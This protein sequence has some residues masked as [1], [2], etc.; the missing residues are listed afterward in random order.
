MNSL[1]KMD[2]IKKLRDSS[3]KKY[4]RMFIERDVYDTMKLNIDEKINAVNK[5][6]KRDILE[7]VQHSESVNNIDSNE[8]NTIINTMKPMHQMNTILSQNFQDIIPDTGVVIYMCCF[9]IYQKYTD[10]TP[11]LSYVLCSGTI[12]NE[13]I[14]T[15]PYKKVVT[16]EKNLNLQQY[17]NV[18]LDDIVGFK[19]VNPIGYLESNLNDKTLY[20]VFYDVKNLIPEV[21]LLKS[22]NNEW[23]FSIASD[24]VYGKK[25]FERNIFEGI[26]ELFSDEP[27]LSIVFD[28][29]KNNDIDELED[30]YHLPITVY[31]IG[32]D[33]YD[34]KKDTGYGPY[35]TFY[36]NYQDA[37]M[38]IENNEM[39]SKKL[40]SRVFVT[41]SENIVSPVSTF[42]SSSE[43]DEQETEYDDIQDVDKNDLGRVTANKWYFNGDILFYKDKVIVKRENDIILVDERIKLSEPNNNSEE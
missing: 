34:T 24:I 33:I 28:G 31:K 41:F 42:I 4:D 43:Y 16:N 35:Y 25:I 27:I 32:E 14:Y 22:E 18:S 36:G 6:I 9:G 7:S 26:R 21:S 37:F 15:F 29:N 1:K 40:I 12:S 11:F 17:T 10:S 8:T 13:D 38:N 5:S 3:Q 20:Y 23:I 30:G 39:D 19:N 2:F